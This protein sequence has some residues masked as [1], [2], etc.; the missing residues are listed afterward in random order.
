MLEATMSL[1]DFSSIR[2][3]PPTQLTPVY[4]EMLKV[5]PHVPFLVKGV[6]DVG[7]DYN[8]WCIIPLANQAELD[9]LFEQCLLMDTGEFSKHYYIEGDILPDNPN[10]VPAGVTTIFGRFIPYDP[11]EELSTV[12]EADNN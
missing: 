5:A 6:D 8:V 3:I 2:A 7:E 1:H 10:L 12:S 4:I 9:K 11:E